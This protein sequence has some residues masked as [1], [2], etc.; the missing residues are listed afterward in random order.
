MQWHDLSS[1]I[2]A[3][4]A[5][6]GVLAGGDGDEAGGVQWAPMKRRWHGSAAQ[7]VHRPAAGKEE[8]C[9]RSIALGNA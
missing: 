9:W 2:S 7:L 1:T 3:I 6:D 5:Q 8:K 4:V